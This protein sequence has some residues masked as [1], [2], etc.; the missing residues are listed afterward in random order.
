MGNGPK[1]AVELKA[2]YS[3]GIPSPL[4]NLLIK[5]GLLTQA[6][7]TGALEFQRASGGRLGEILQAWNLVSEAQVAEA[8]AEI[9]K[10]PFVDVSS[11][12]FSS[13]QLNLLPEYL[14]R[15][16]TCIALEKQGRK[17]KVVMTD[18]RDLDAVQ[19]ISFAT[20]S[21]VEPF[22]G[23]RSQIL[24]AIDRYYLRHLEGAGALMA[25]GA[26]GAEDPSQVRWGH[27]NALEGTA[28]DGPVVQLLNLVLRKAI[29]LGAS[30]IHIEPGS[31]E[32]IV[33]F[34]L[35][36]LLADQLQ[37]PSGILPSL[38]SRLKILGRMDITDRRLPQ[39]GSVRVKLDGREM[40]LRLST[41]PLRLGEKAVIRV[42]DAS[43]G[44]FELDSIGFSSKDLAKV[45]QLI[46]RHMGMIIM[47]GPTGS[48]KTTTL[49]SMLNRIKNR[50]I[51]IVTVED[52]IEYNY[53]GLN[54]M[55][56]N[57]DINLTFASGLRSILRQDP[58]VILVGEI[59]DIETAEIA[60]RAALTG[61]LVFSTLHTNDAPSTITR[62]LD[63]GVPGYL[64]ASVISGIIAQ[65]L[66]R[67]VCSECCNPAVPNLESLHQFGLPAA[68][69]ADA[70]FQAGE[71]CTHCNGKGFKGRMGVFE[72]LAMDPRI[73]DLILRGASEEDLRLAAREGA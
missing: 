44:A 60:C 10:I 51:N 15:R 5:K 50:A 52:P 32:G 27:A 56:V 47:T 29:Q 31:L 49:Y 22:M 53:E 25:A 35:D 24:E 1:S 65:R 18:P 16:H 36:G 20:S 61:H 42:L 68:S 41:I 54:Q 34:R 66:V 11:I 4:G 71:G 13:E 38:V 72:T 17:L 70:N 3:A 23:S 62:L 48:G 9:F 12:A 6:D 58:D 69:V 46:N 55:Q 45:D 43:G 33:R 39:D 63:I 40:D 8:L 37:V 7:L 64:A 67:R 14:A 30:D 26:Q 19:D 73:R 28:D 2:A 59:R 57:P 21:P